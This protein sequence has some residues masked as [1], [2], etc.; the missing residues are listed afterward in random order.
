[1]SVAARRPSV[2]RRLAAATVACAVAGLAATACGGM[3]PPRDLKAPSVSVAGLSV[4][5]VTAER[6][7][8]TVRLAT[9]NPNAVD[10][11]LSNVRLDFS[12]LGQPLLAGAPVEAEFTLPAKGSR[13]VPVSFTLT[14]ADLRAVVSKLLSGPLPDTVWTLR[15]T[16]QWGVW[17]LP[18]P[19]ER[20]GDARSVRRLLEVL[21]F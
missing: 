16:A 15:G 9:E 13:E 20:S 2:L 14:S 8:F 19:F 5:S 11:P 3:L 21:R 6:A 10:I 4:D 7:R 1:M 18:I 12:L 17:P